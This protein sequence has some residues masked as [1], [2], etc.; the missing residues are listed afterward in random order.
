[1]IN[2]S[3]DSAILLASNGANVNIVFEKKS[4][5]MLSSTLKQAKVASELMRR[6]AD[7]SFCTKAGTAVHFAVEEDNEQLMNVLM[8]DKRVR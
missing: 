3:V 4:A 8:A 1:M 2:G 6:G 5:L 7:P